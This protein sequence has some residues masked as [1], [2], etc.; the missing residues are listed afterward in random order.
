MSMLHAAL[1]YRAAGIPI[2]PVARNKQPLAGHGF[3][4]ATT[5]LDTIERWFR[6]H[7]E[8]GIAIPTGP[9]SGFW[10]LDLDLEKIDPKTGEVIQAGEVTLA[11]LVERYGPLP[12]TL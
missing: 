2:F 12:E 11:A 10:V 7:P 9:A 4:D 1:D 3:H 6:Q 8:A 5:D